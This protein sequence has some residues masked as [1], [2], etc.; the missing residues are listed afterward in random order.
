VTETGWLL[1][2]GDSPT[3]SPRY[4]AAGQI[5]PSRSSA[6]TEN[7]NHAIRF[8]RRIDAERVATRLMRKIPLEVRICQHEWST[9]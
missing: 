2:H 7:H 8:A 9:T 5:D 3:N 6:W 1:E 4:W